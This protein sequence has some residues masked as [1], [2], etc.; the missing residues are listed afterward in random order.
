MV[1]QRPGLEQGEVPPAAGTSRI[2]APG[3]RGRARDRRIRR[4]SRSSSDPAEVGVEHRAARAGVRPPRPP[5][6]AGR[7]CGIFRPHSMPV[8]QDG[9]VVDGMPS[10][11]MSP[12]TMYMPYCGPS[13]RA[14]PCSG[15]GSPPRAEIGLEFPSF[16]S[17]SPGRRC[18]AFPWRSRRGP[19]GRRPRCPGNCAGAGKRCRCDPSGGRRR[20]FLKEDV[21][22]PHGPCG[23]QP[24][25]ALSSRTRPAAGPAR[26]SS[27][28]S[29]PVDRGLVRVVGLGGALSRRVQPVEPRH[30][31]PSLVGNRLGA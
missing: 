7:A 18:P 24:S 20:C 23:A 26:S 11:S 16:S 27:P 1:L 3:R 30:N 14:C 2:S 8:D 17:S 28:A 4:P 29:I 12:A 19:G 22:P 9:G 31:L 21:I 13:R 15:R 5:R 6:A 25:S 10:R